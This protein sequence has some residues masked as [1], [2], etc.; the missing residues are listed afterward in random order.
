MSI[1]KQL[2]T[3]RKCFLPSFQN[4]SRSSRLL[5]PWNWRQRSSPK[6][7][8]LF[9]NQYEASYPFHLESSPTPLCES[10]TS[11]S[12]DNYLFNTVSVMFIKTSTVWGRNWH[13]L[14]FHILCVYRTI[15]SISKKLKHFFALFKTWLEWSNQGR[16]GRSL[17]TH[18]TDTNTWYNGDDGA[19]S[20][21][22][23]ASCCTPPPQPRHPRRSE[24]LLAWTLVAYVDYHVVI[25]NNIGANGL[26]RRPAGKTRSSS[27][28][29]RMGSIRALVTP[30]TTRRVLL[31]ARDLLTAEWLLA[32]RDSFSLMQLLNK[33][34]S[35]PGRS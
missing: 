9:R 11:Y 12:A 19:R 24:R 25:T 3:V 31:Q 27:M 18:K 14:H 33:A 4:P 29:M 16:C 10:Q 1:C 8:W 2:P 28:D 17:T 35:N 32:S 5:R 26:V 23:S 15:S 22:L 20:F 6:R 34:G 30:L 13:K 7:R 21:R